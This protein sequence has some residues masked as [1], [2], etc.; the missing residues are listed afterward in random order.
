MVYGPS[1]RQ[2]WYH[3]LGSDKWSARERQLD[4]QSHPV[5]PLLYA[6][7]ESCVGSQDYFLN[8]FQRPRESTSLLART[9]GAPRFVREVGRVVV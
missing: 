2:M 6:E 8:G 3:R 4:P 1:Q 5:R 7:L 9:T